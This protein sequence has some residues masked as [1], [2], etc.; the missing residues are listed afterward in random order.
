MKM[1]EPRSP[2]KVQD[3]DPRT[4]KAASNAALEDCM[5]KM[6]N[7]PQDIFDGMQR[8]FL[9]PAQPGKRI[10]LELTNQS[11][12]QNMHPVAETKAERQALF[13]RRHTFDFDDKA[14]TAYV[15][16][17]VTKTFPRRHSFVHNCL[18]NKTQSNLDF[19]EQINSGEVLNANKRRILAAM[20]RRGVD[21]RM[22]RAFKNALFDADELA[23]NQYVPVPVWD[24]IGEYE[25][26]RRLSANGGELNDI[27]L[28][29]CLDKARGMV[30]LSKFNDLVDLFFYKQKK[31]KKNARNESENMWYVMS[32]NV[33]A[34]PVGIDALK[35]QGGPVKKVLDLLWI[36]VSEKFR[37]LAEAYRFFDVNFNNRVSF[38]EFQ[39]ALDHLH[40]K[41]QVSQMQQIFEYLDRGN[42]GYC[43]YQDFCQ[44]AEEKRRNLDPITDDHIPRDP[45]VRMTKG[46]WRATYMHDADVHDLEE[47]ARHFSGFSKTVRT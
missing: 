30:D 34:G 24:E 28:S 17:P 33:H 7:N 20:H 47:M 39:K 40:I 44:M 6:A 5:H 11:A 22:L 41:F 21:F 18:A 19:I 15:A 29:E 1:P 2:F 42:K 16:P 37:G 26:N 8:E 13:H 12:S 25:M 4:L 10:F 45:Q 27:I 14:E 35:A 38:N 9:G 3:F 32:S 36:K 23:D 43:S 31:L 46:D